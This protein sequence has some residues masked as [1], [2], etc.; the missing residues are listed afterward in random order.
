MAQDPNGDVVDAIKNSTSSINHGTSSGTMTSADLIDGKIGKAIDFDGSDDYINCGSNSS[1]DDINKMT[2]ET[3]FKAGGWGEGSSGRVISKSDVGNNDGWNVIIN[4]YGGD[5]KFGLLV[6]WDTTLGIW[7]TP[8]SSITLNDWYYTVVKYDKSYGVSDKPIL[9]LN[10]TSKTVTTDQAP[11]GTIES[12]AAES[13]LIAA[14][15]AATATD[16]E[17]DGTIDEVR[18]SNIYRS[19]EWIKA[20]YYSNWN[21]LITYGVEQERPVFLFNGYVKVEGFP[22]ARTVYLYK[23]STGELVGDVISSPSTGYFEVG[24]HCNEY[25]FVVILPELTE[26]YN[27]LSYDKIDPG[28]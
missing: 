15:K 25:H 4:G 14:R 26:T 7:Y 17:F 3:T 16:R 1:L 18:I 8:N 28:V 6:G 11:V 23:R 2:I 20:T 19:S 27:L 12:D 24:S 21:S 5:N 13:V 10:G 9:Y 22:A